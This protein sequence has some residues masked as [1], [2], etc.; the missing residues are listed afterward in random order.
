M[1]CCCSLP[2][3][4]RLRYGIRL[5]RPPDPGEPPAATSTRILLDVNSLPFRGALLEWLHAETQRRPAPRTRRRWRS[6]DCR[7]DAAHLNLFDEIANAQHH[8]GCPGGVQTERIGN[9]IRRTCFDYVGSSV[10]DTIVWNASRRAIV[11][12]DV[13]AGRRIDPNIE[14]MDVFPDIRVSLSTWIKAIRLHQW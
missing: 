12:G 13:G 2:N 1:S 5:C 9:A 7:T 11:V 6:R 14:V 8:K 4:R 3:A 10:A